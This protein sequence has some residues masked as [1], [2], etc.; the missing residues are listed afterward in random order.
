V[1]EM[2]ALMNLA[3]KRFLKALRRYLKFGEIIVPFRNI[4]MPWSR[5]T[6]WR[7]GSVLVQKDFQAVGLGLTDA[8]DTGLA[9]AISHDCDIAND[10]LYIEPAVEFIFACILDQHKGNFTHGKNPRILHLDYIHNGQTVW[11]EL[12]ASRKVVVQKN[13]LEAIQP[14]Q[15]YS[16][17]TRQTLKSWLAER[18]RRIALPNSLVERLRT[19]STYIEKEG[20]RNSFGILSFRLNYEP[21]DE[22]LPEEPYELW[23][24]IIYVA[25][26]AEYGLMA[27]NLAQKLKTEFPNLLEKTKDSGTVDLRACKAV[28]ET[29]FTLRDLRD[30]AEYHL[31]HLSYRTEP[32][33]PVI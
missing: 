15:T 1:Q 32:S 7:Q 8:P 24:T 9:I 20:K 4:E 21:K 30:T 28:S 3:M 26:N 16:L 31:E 29:E 13:L 12:I 33:G 2:L 23:L 18:Y 27:A 6:K 10:D 19:V 11:I 14:D 5:N 17:I 25:D 22:L